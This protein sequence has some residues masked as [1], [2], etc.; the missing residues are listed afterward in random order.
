MYTVYTCTYIY[1]S[2]EEMLQGVTAANM[3]TS[4]VPLSQFFLMQAILHFAT[5]FDDL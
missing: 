1:L 2:A 3:N 4:A 5:R